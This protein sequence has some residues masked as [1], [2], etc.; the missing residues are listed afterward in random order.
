MG[1]YFTVGTAPKYKIMYL[2]YPF[3]LPIIYLGAYLE[4]IRK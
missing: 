4:N 3:I 1:I 2:I